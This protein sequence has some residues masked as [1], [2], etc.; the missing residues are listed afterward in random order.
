MKAWD[1]K[2]EA[3]TTGIKPVLDCVG[4]APPKGATRLPGDLPPRTIVDQCWTAWSDFK[5]FTCSAAHRAIIHTLVVLRSHYPSL[6]PKVKMTGFARG[7]NGQK[8]VK[9]EDEVEEAAAKLARD[10]DL[11][12]KGQDNV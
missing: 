8:I 11:F 12:G 5:E 3:V 10:V 9:L 7:M 1:D 6:K 4:F 2:L